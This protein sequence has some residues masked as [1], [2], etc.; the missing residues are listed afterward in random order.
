MLQLKCVCVQMLYL[1]MTS[2]EK[3]LKSLHY[4]S[5]DLVI[6][7]RR[8][9]E[10]LANSVHALT[11]VENVHVDCFG[12]LLLFMCGLWHA[13]CLGCVENVMCDVWGTCGIQYDLQDV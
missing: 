7:R 5:K 10:I 4:L 13:W 6:V 3:R 1:I 9:N 11:C 2:K 8:Q 12:F